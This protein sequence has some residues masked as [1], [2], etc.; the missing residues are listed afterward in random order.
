M[1]KTVLASKFTEWRGLDRVS[2][3]V[4]AMNCIFR[5]LSKDDFG[6]DGEIEVVRPKPG[7]TG[8]ETT[9]GIIKVQAKAG[10]SYVVSD[11]PASFASPVEKADLQYWQSCTFP[12]LYVVYHPADDK[13]YFREVK[14]YLHATPNV[15]QAP[16]RVTFDKARDEF[17]ASAQTAVHG[18]ARVS[19]P[20]ITFGV[21]ERLISNLLPVTKLPKFLYFAPTRRKDAQGIRR[22][23]D[24]FVPPFTVTE[25]KLY[26][27]SN[28][29]DQN[30]VLRKWCGT[31]VRKMLASE[32][33]ADERHVPEWVYLLNQLLGKHAGRCGL[34]YSPDFGRNYFPRQNDTDTEFRRAWTSVR[35]GKTAPAR[36]VAKRYEYGRHR[37]WRHLAAE[38]AYRH[39]GGSWFL[40]VT[41]KYFFTEDGTRPWDSDLVG[42]YS[43]SQKAN[44]HNPQVMNHVL[45]WADMLAQGEDKVRMKLDGRTLL[46]VDKM[47]ACGVGAFGIP[48]DPAG[49][50]EKD[51]EPPGLFSN[52][53]DDEDEEDDEDD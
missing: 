22:E 19:P 48:D 52:V 5:E 40:Q 37:F 7:G 2:Q 44:E 42:P 4:H 41:P 50:E 30:C 35:T 20:R 29:F 6:L 1:G 45:F 9:G 21:Q 13:L 34:R 46:V 8:F 36:I 33:L 27:L 31:K 10:M 26:T 28:L 16:H 32:W 3:V 38:L 51:E 53:P 25:G 49:Y 17:A 12:V 47:P 14:E 11:T 23:I 24:G 18:H 43:T 15:F 39:F